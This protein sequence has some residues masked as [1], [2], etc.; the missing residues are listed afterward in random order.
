MKR[1]HLLFK[2]KTIGT[3]LLTLWILGTG[4]I[5]SA[6]ADE[7]EYAT[8]SRLTTKS[9]LLDATRAGDRMVAVGHWGHIILS[10]DNGET[11]RQA[12]VVPTRKNLTSV[13]FVDA[14]KGWATGHDQVILH[15]SDGGENWE[16]QYQDIEAEVPLLSIWFQNAQHGI[17]CGGFGT[18]VETKDGGQT[19]RSRGIDHT[20]DEVHLNEIFPGPEGTIFIGAEMGL[21]YRS[22]DEGTSWTRLD[23][24]YEGS[25]WGG[26]TQSDGAILLFGMRGHIF[27]SPDLG[28]SWV[29][30]QTTSDDNQSFSGGIQLRNGNIVLGGLGGSIAF[31]REN[32]SE[33]EAMNLEH[34][35]GISAVAQA[36][37]G[38][39]FLFGEFGVLKAPAEVNRAR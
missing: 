27:R 12:K 13:S 3:A 26:L 5:N 16:L 39:V 34:R 9:L 21:A 14:Q 29:E 19:W 38:S 15:T 28:E 33:F 23:P 25:F 11:W 1:I 22:R 37:N 8:P 6:Q 7:I 31:G 24:A 35:R 30:I 20:G 10:D 36:A 2:I 32:S 4:D 18:I 17:A